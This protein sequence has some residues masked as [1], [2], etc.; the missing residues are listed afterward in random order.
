[1]TTDAR[2]SRRFLYLYALAASGGAIAYT[3]F[4][5]ILLPLRATEL[6]GNNALSL[7]AIAAFAGA[8]S[9]SLANVG[10]GWRSDVSRTRRPWIVA[11]LILSS[12]LLLAIPLV[13][14]ATILILMIVGWQIGLN[15]MLAPLAAWA[16][17]CVPD[18]QKGML[19]GLLA[20]APALGALSG[21]LVTLPGIAATDG[22]HMLVVVMVVFM[23]SPVVLF[24]R[25]QPMPHLMQE[26]S[27]REIGRAHV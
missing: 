11:G 14:D 8:I 27:R 24:G 6:A 4:L 25:P 16:G 19:G 9:A 26:A 15:M 10:F 21:A 13:T 17:D 5:T 20:F 12:V 23:V 2:Q 1:M 22:R 18:S 7:L 3:P